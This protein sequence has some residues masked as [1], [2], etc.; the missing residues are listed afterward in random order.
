M[1]IS[2]IQLVFGLCVLS[3]IST[4]AESTNETSGVTTSSARTESEPAKLDEASFHIISERN[5]FNANRS[6]GSVR[7]SNTRR[8]ARVETVALVGT[9]AY[10]KGAF[11]FFEGSSSEFTKVLK[12]NGVIAGYKLV[13]IL[14]NAVKLEMDGQT[15][16]IPIGSGLRREDQSAWKISDS[17]ASNNGAGG[18]SSTS[19]SNGRYNRNDRSR[20]G[21]DSERNGGRSESVTSTASGAPVSS[22]EQSEILKRLM[23]RRE[24]ESQ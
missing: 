14:A 1:K 8:P 10:E 6:G 16:E 15:I 11:A 22:A 13:D 3:A 9:M 23:E 19:E 12:A 2:S 21:D 17:V 5:I 4:H 18:S 24:K 7:S 20:R